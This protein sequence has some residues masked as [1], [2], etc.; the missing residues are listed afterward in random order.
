M[1]FPTP[2]KIDEEQQKRL[3]RDRTD[4]VRIDVERKFSYSLAWNTPDYEVVY[5]NEAG[6]VTAVEKIKTELELSGWYVV[7]RQTHGKRCIK[8]TWQEAP[9]SLWQRF[10]CWLQS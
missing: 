7:V 5:P 3:N 10:A 2:T 1:T 4:I 6:Y 8:M 9:R